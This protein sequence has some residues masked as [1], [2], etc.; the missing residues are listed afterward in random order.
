MKNIKFSVVIPAYNAQKTIESTVNSCLSQEYSPLEIIIINDCST[1]ETVDLLQSLYGNNPK[2]QIYSFEKNQG[3]SRARNFG[4]RQAK[5]DYIAF[6]D[7]DDVWRADKLE[8]ISRILED[9][10]KILCIGHN[11]T[12]NIYCFNQ[13]NN[14][15]YKI[16]SRKHL[17]FRNY[18]NTSSFVVSNVIQERFDETMSYTEDHDLY[19][20]I[21]DYT[22]ICYINEYLTL[23][24]RPQLSKGGLS[25]NRL[26]MRKG[27]L[28]M[29]Y[30]FCK[31]NKPYMPFLPFY[32]LFSFTKYLIKAITNK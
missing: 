10:S 2:V 13:Y 6:L 16:L 17:L 11:Y 30:K 4:W 27:E 14:V 23:L 5:G 19:L 32:L 18:F 12:A 9:D 26:N 29:Y 28:Y 21:L 3:V 31:R 22:K 1:D 7:S 15:E 20:R 24:G 25:G 8:L